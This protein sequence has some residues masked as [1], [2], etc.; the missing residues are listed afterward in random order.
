ML[1]QQKFSSE[2]RTYNMETFVQVMNKHMDYFV[3]SQVIYNMEHVLLT[4]CKLDA[5][6]SVFIAI[7]GVPHKAKMMEQRQRKYTGAVLEE[8]KHLLLEYY[9]PQL[10]KSAEFADLYRIQWSRNNISTSSR[11]MKTL[12]TELNAWMT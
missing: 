10:I 8:C 11:F 1:K 6:K 3:I 5:L 7:D 4:Y 9:K 2:N 12:V